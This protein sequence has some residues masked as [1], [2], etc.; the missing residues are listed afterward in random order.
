MEI[1]TTQI[2]AVEKIQIQIVGVHATELFDLAN[3]F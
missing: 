1:D 2:S 3:L